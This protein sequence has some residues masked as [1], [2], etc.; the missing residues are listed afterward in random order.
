MLEKGEE[1][2]FVQT[3]YNAL[4]SLRMEKSFGIWSREFTWAYTP[5]MSGMDRFV[6]FDKGP[7]TGRNAALRERD[8]APPARRL[9]TLE[10][11][12]TDADASG[13]EPVWDGDRRIG[14]VT[15]GAYGH[16]VGK[17]LALAYLDREAIAD[18]ARYDVHIVETKRKAEVLSGPVFDPKGTRM[19]G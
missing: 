6:A 11:D 12:S 8:E 9:V 14:F 16:C 10:I 13:F 18:G 5:G 19:R 2:G 17:S 7:F 15:S 4:L 3:G 1:L